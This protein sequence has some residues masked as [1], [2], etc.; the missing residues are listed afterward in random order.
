VFTRASLSTVGTWKMQAKFE[1]KRSFWRKTN[2]STAI[3]KKSQFLLDF[4]RYFRK[5]YLQGGEKWGIWD[6]YTCQFLTEV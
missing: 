4:Q 5:F 6:K 1:T 2:N 3:L